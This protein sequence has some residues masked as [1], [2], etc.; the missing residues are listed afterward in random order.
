MLRPIVRYGADVLHGPA[1]PVEAVTP[2]IQ[3]LIDDMIQTMYAAPGLGVVAAY[4]RIIPESLLNLPRLGMIN[5][6]ASLLPRYRGA[7]PVQRAVI[8]GVPLT[9]ITIMRVVAALD[10]GGMFATAT[11]PIGSDE[12]SEVVERGLADLGASLLL[13][14]ID[15]LVA[16]TA[17]EKPQDDRLSTYAAKVTKEEGLV[18]WSLPA[19]DIHNRIRGLYPWPHAYTYLGN[20]RLILLRSHVDSSGGNEPP[21]TIVDTSGGVLHVATGQSGRLTIDEVQPG[22]R[23]AMT[24][25]DYLAGHPI[26]PGG[27]FTGR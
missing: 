19:I 3:T 25:R 5:V 7:A 18:D 1:A 17:V 21:G 12:T 27:R 23:R 24:T 22:G 14:V 13:D 4:G 8:D 26:P 20:E 2:E 16:G 10:A 15:D 6:H 11:R 9:G